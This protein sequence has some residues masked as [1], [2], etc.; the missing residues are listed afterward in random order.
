MD[1]AA[2]KSSIYGAGGTLSTSKGEGLGMVIGRH[3]W[4]QRTKRWQTF[5]ARWRLVTTGYGGVTCGSWG[6]GIS[7]A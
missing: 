6:K 3:L 5:L 7:R 4:C 1:R 2:V